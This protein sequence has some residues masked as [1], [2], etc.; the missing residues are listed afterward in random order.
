VFGPTR[1]AAERVACKTV[2]GGRHRY[3]SSAAIL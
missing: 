3:R 2:F 1:S